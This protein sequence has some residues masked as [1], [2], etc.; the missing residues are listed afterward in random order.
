MNL[1]ILS[2]HLL[3]EGDGKIFSM[4]LYLA[5]ETVT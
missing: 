1:T 3:E 5:F 2:N 4:R